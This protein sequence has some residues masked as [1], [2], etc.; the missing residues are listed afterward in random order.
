MMESLD[1]EA[2]RARAAE[3]TETV[4]HNAPPAASPA[5]IARLVPNA[6]KA[7]TRFRITEYVPGDP[8]KLSRRMWL[9]P[10]TYVRKFITATVSPGGVGKTGLGLI[11]ALAMAIG[12]DL[13]GDGFQGTPLR[14]FFWN[15]E[16]PFEE[17]ERQLHAALIHY[18]IDP[19]EIV[20][21][22]FMASG[23][24]LP[25]RVAYTPERGGF[26]LD[27][28][29]MD[30]IEAA[31]REWSIDVAIFDP[32]VS[33]HKVAENSNEAMDLVVKSLAQLANDTNTAIGV[34]A[35]TRKPAAGGNSEVT[36][37]DARGG[38]ALV[39]GAR[40]TRVLNRMTREEAEKAGVEGSN[41]YKRYF[42][43]GW[44]KVNL[45]PPDEDTS[46][47]YMASVFLPNGD[48]GEDGDSMRV[49]TAWRWPD[50]F[51][52]VTVAHMEAIRRKIAVPPSAGDYWRRDVQSANWAGLAVAEV[53]GADVFDKSQK[54]TVS[55]VLKTWIATG[56]LKME[57]LQCPDRKVRP[58]VV[59]GTE[60]LK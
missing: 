46:W 44:D 52:N 30:E 42:R 57:N 19:Q 22:F 1:K 43:V 37:D 24:E 32:L 29:C 15:G 36:A 54:E 4:R 40:V 21:Q 17:M 55:Q 35:H 31:F 25:I 20:G 12:R 23:R 45:T 8:S 3:M 38:R 7:R 39:D 49:V 33:I 48:N 34:A 14:V 13:L 50:A 18:Q 41:T 5:P 58:C 11:E 26:A 2:I 10:R 28:E 27:Q 16:D 51:A 47:R 56:V 9:Y 59:C 60:S 6:P 53:I